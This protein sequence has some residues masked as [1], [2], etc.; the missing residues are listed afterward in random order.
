MALANI[1]VETKF[2]NKYIKK[3][4]A[5]NYENFLQIHHNL[6]LFWIAFRLNCPNVLWIKTPNFDKNQTV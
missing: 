6:E 5:H 2:Y 3:K 1:N 4:T